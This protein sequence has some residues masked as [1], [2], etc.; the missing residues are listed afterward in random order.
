MHFNPRQFGFKKVARLLMHVFYLKKLYM[1]TL[2][3][4]TLLM[5]HLLTYLRHLIE[6]TIFYLVN[7]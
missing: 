7:S 5:L 2:K 1:N 3:I 6:L 4:E